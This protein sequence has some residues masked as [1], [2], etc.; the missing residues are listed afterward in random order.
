M[1]EMPLIAPAIPN[2]SSGLPHLL[3]DSET[4]RN[5]A[6]DISKVPRLDG[7]VG[8]ARAGKH[9]NTLRDLLLKV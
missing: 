3:P 7:P 1:L 4:S 8:P 2:V 9:A 5:S 6:V